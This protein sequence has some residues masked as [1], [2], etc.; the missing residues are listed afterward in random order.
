MAGRYR[1][2]HAAGVHARG[3]GRH[4]RPGDP[5]ERLAAGALGLLTAGG[6]VVGWVLFPHGPEQPVEVPAAAVAAPFAYDAVSYRK[7]VEQEVGH[8]LSD[9]NFAKVEEIAG[10]ACGWEADQFDDWV[11]ANTDDGTLN[12]VYIDITHRCPDRER[13][14]TAAMQRIDEARACVM[15]VDA[16]PEF[17]ALTDTKPA[18]AALT[19][20]FLQSVDHS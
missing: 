20:V 12:K 14:I 9:L 3:R 7:A 6:F 11:A 5:R 4:A 16:D 13:D 15:P 1:G 18:Q 8:K 19:C 10:L 17:R 2:R